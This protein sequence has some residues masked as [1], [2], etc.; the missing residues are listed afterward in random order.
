MKKDELAT[1]GDLETLRQYLINHFYSKA[2]TLEDLLAMEK[3]L[4]EKIDRNMT[5]SKPLFEEPPLPNGGERPAHFITSSDARE[6]L[7]C[8]GEKL[9]IYRDKNMLPFWKRGAKTFLYD[10][11]DVS[12]L[13]QQLDNPSAESRQESD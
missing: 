11:E 3:R 2:V 5:K 12:K 8:T 10:L 6:I 7:G 1:H 13:K 4:T 9:K